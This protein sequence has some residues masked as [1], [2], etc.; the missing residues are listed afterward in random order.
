ME[1][2]DD[3]FCLVKVIVGEVQIGSVHVGDDYFDIVP[4]LFIDG[5]EVVIEGLLIAVGQY[6]DNLSCFKVE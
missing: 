3:A 5:V 2:I 4:F 6:V 1:G